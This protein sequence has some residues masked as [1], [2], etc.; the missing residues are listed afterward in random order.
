M[1]KIREMRI[2][3]FG[4]SDVLTADEVEPSLADASQVRGQGRKR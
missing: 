1:I 2:H 3:R 4:D